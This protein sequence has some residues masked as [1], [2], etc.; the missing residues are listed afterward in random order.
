MLLAADMI[1]RFQYGRFKFIDNGDFEEHQHPRGPD[2]KFTAGA[3]GG[4][5]IQN[6]MVFPKA[7]SS[8]KNK[9]WQSAHEYHQKFGNYPSSNQNRKLKW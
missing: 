6:G 7:G 9:I 1:L 3:A 5:E 2:G 4:K 8:A